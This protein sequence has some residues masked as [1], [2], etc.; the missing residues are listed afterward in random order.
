M[1]KRISFFLPNYFFT[2]FRFLTLRTTTLLRLF[3]ELYDYNRVV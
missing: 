3:Y 2:F 1:S